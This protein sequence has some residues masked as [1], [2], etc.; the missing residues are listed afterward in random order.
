MNTPTQ[1]TYT[2]LDTAYDFFNERLFDGRLPRCLITMQRKKHAYGYFAGG[3]F[4]SRD[5]DNAKIDEI[6]LN[7]S[8]FHE[9]SVEAALSTLVHEMAHLWQQH[10]GK[11][12]KRGYHNKE[13]AEEMHRIGLKP[14]AAD[15]S[16]RETGTKVTH[17]IMTEG[18]FDLVCK[19][20]MAGHGPLALPYVEHKDWQERAGKTAKAKRASKTRYTCPDCDQH[21]WAKPGAALVCGTCD[22][23]MEAA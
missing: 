19:E 17:A 16:G 11:P 14:I 5:D 18:P 20:F 9:R 7:P 21:A 6:A 1:T 23:E 3:R 4:V 15:G 8:T 22:L 12:G 13:W 10:Y 2:T